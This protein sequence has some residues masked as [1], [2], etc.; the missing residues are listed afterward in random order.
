MDV[1]YKIFL[2][3]CAGNRNNVFALRQHPGQRKLRC[4]H[5]LFR[6]HLFDLLHEFKIAI[7][8][9]ALKSRRGSP[10]VIGRKIAGLLDLSRKETA[11]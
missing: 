2:P 11:A 8:V 10:P 7:E 9:F 5:S 4:L 1:L 3:F 6:R